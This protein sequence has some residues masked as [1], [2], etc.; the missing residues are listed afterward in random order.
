MNLNPTR[1]WRQYPRT[2]AIAALIVGVGCAVS[3]ALL[4]TDAPWVPKCLFHTLTGLDCPGCGSQRAIHAALN[5][6]FSQAWQFNPALW[7]GLLLA[8]LYAAFPGSRQPAGRIERVLYS[9]WT[10]SSISIAIVVWT[11]IRNL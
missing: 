7:I 6:R 3:L 10:L 11:I 9:P 8:I 4:G 2:V 1:L 5:G